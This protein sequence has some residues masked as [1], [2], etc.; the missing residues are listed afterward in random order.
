[1]PSL[2]LHGAQAARGDT[3]ARLGAKLREHG[4]RAVLRLGVRADSE[5]RRTALGQALLTALRSLRAP[6]SDI[7]AGSERTD[8]F[9]AA[10]APLRFTTNLSVS[11][12]LALSGWPVGDDRY[13]GLPAAHPKLLR[14]TRPATEGVFAQS[15][16]PGASVPVGIDSD[17]RRYHAWVVGPTGT[18]KSV[19]LQRLI[20]DDLR[21]GRSVVVLDPQATLVR[22]VLERIPAHRYEDMV[23]L[24]PSQPRPVGLNPLVVPGTAPEL[25]ADGLLAVFR[26]LFG[27]SLGPRTTDVL[28]ASLLTLA[29]HGGASLTWLPRLLTDPAFRHGLTAQL[30]DAIGLGG[31][32][33][34]YE[35]YSPQQQ[36]TVIAPTLSRLRQLLL[37]PSLRAVLEQVQPRFALSDVFT[38]PRVLLVPLN[39][40]LL[41]ADAARLFGSLLVSSLWQHTLARGGVLAQQRR[42]VSIYLDEAQD[43]LNLPI[44][45]AEALA[46]S[47][48]MNVA[49]TLAHQYRAQF[50]SDLLPGIDAN[51]RNKIVFRLEPADAAV[52]A[53]F[54]PEL[55]AIDF[56]SLDRYEVYTRTLREGRVLPW[57]SARTLPPPPRCSNELDL[58]AASQARYGALAPDPEA[59]A[60]TEPTPPAGRSFG[61]RRR[62]P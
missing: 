28:H 43:V 56:Q 1:M 23:V 57:V 16:A 29:S 60:A 17:A 22:D 14:P 35:A 12:V 33:A 18:G 53:T 3:A 38:K 55:G 42:P 27:T 26:G 62:Q 52:M 51:A 9:D 37:R 7:T 2:V 20:A 4:F 49:W 41:G 10:V 36:A 19:V 11:E 48:A 45:I 47:R 24:D 50:P 39:A 31:F 32:W 25:V 6:G 61:R 21:A 59:A 46:R 8:A 54:A 13:P 34:E 30:D 58:R 40:A 44:D 15:T 5:P